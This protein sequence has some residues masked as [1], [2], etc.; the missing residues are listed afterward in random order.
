MAIEEP[1]KD[2]NAWEEWSEIETRDK[3]NKRLM[4]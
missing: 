3:G 2:V 1:K 4:W